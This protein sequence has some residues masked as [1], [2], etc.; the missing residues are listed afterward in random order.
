MT[1][2]QR[3]GEDKAIGATAV[4]RRRFL[5]SSWKVLSVA[6]V[7]EGLWT[8][9]DL[10][11]PTEA[12]GSSG[13]VDAGPVSDY[14]AEGTVTYSLNGG[15]YL[16]QYQGALRA[17]YQKCPHLGCKV[18]W[19][20]AAGEFKCPCHGSVYNVIGEYEAGPAPRGLDRYAVSIKNGQVMVDTTT[21]VQ[22]PPPGTHDG[23]PPGSVGGTP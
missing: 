20:P 12:A 23:P 16:T 3:T 18:P 1:D 2:Q 8:S 21:L 5:D 14:M 19:D 17:L 9:Y 6:L 4:P 11:K 7:A 15:F 10:L 13:V 22:G